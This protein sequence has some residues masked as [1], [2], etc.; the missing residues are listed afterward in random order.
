MRQFDL[1]PGRAGP[2]LPCQRL[3]EIYSPFPGREE[4]EQDS[5]VAYFQGKGNSTPAFFQAFVLAS[6][7]G[8]TRT[9]NVE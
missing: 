7:G 2:C 5:Q 6:I 9:Y 3:C 1:Q 4:C 8:E